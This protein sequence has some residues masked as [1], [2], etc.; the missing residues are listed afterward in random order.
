LSGPRA[1]RFELLEQRDAPVVRIAAIADAMVYKAVRLRALREDPAA[2]GATYGEESR[3]TD[4]EWERRLENPLGVVW[5]A[6]R[7]AEPCGLA[8]GVVDD[9]TRAQLV[10]MWMAPEGAKGGGF[11][12]G[13]E[14]RG[15]VLPVG[16]SP[17]NS[18]P[19][20]R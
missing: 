2:F 8:R 16:T 14:P 5:L 17:R 4:A 11:E 3:L 9:A 15:D 6:F 13:P 7:D 19:I 20:L 12:R 10:S 1:E 18:L